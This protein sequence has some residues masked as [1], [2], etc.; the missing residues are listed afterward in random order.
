MTDYRR[1]VKLSESGGSH[2]TGA[3]TTGTYTSG[4]LTFNLDYNDNDTLDI[5]IVTNNNVTSSD[6]VSVTP[7]N[8]KIDNS[9]S[10]QSIQGGDVFTISRSG[11]GSYKAELEITKKTGG[12]AENPTY[13]V[14]TAEV[15]GTFI[16]DIPNAF[17]FTNLANVSTGSVH[18]DYVIMQGFTGS[19]TISRTSGSILFAVSSGTSQ[20]ASSAFTA[21]NKTVT[22]GQYLH[23]KMTA[24]SSFSTTVSGT[25]SC[26]GVTSTWNIE[27]VSQDTTAN[28]F[29]FG[30]NVTGATRDQYYYA[31]AQITGFTGTLTASRTSGTSRGSVPDM[32]FDV[33]SGTSIS[34]LQFQSSPHSITNGQYLHVR[35]RASASYSTE[36]NG[37]MTV[38]GQSVSWSVTTEAQDTTPDAFD[39][40]DVTGANLD[41]DVIS[42][43][44]ITGITGLVN[45]S[46][47]GTHA[48]C[49]ASLSSTP[50]AAD[51]GQYASSGTIE[52]NMYLHVLIPTANAFNNTR[53]TTI[54]VGDRTDSYS[55]TTR[56]P[57][58][59]I[60]QFSLGANITGATRGS[61]HY[62]SVQINNF[63]S[64]LAVSLTINSFSGTNAGMG[65]LIS[66]S[67]TAP[68]SGYTTTS[69]TMTQGQYIHVQLTAATSF[70]GHIDGTLTAGT[71][72][73]AK[74][75]TIRITTEAADTTPNAF[76]FTNVTGQEP[77]TQIT[78]A[79]EITGINTTTSV[80]VSGGGA[81]F[82]TSSSPS[83]SPSTFDTNN[84]FVGSGSID[85]VHVRMNAPTTFSATNTCTI[86]IGTVSDTFSVT[87]RAADVTPDAFSLGSDITDANLEAEYVRNARILGIEAGV[88]ASISGGSA[89]FAVSNSTSVPT[90]SNFTASNKTVTNGQ[91]VH[92]KLAAS[93]SGNTTTSTTLTVGG[94]TDSLSITTGSTSGTG[95]GG[96]SVGGGGASIGNVDYGLT[97]FGPDGTTEVFGSNVRQTNL[98]VLSSISLSNGSS[99][100]FNCAF[101]NDSSKVFIQ[102]IENS[103]SR[104]GTL[105][106]TTTST[107]FTVSNNTG[108]TV[109]ASVVAYRIA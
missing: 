108:V 43:R 13:T 101:A 19:L 90:S 58:Q 34:G 42:T 22:S 82:G 27:T 10:A 53:S 67:S 41:A 12:T 47:S 93:A 37:T 57:N 35:L 50:P 109:G 79:K 62:R 72:S 8:C 61:V 54:T 2:T 49:A 1:N 68:T 81:T 11:V 15:N 29:S 32:Q 16:D 77:G 80:S 24:S 92:V 95:S 83:I 70:S 74:S 7:T 78:Q 4:A 33:G 99:Q 89:T 105:T 20:P 85:S 91:Y 3:S 52:N 23:V 26:G 106:L 5:G 75:D 18:Y 60:S 38:G 48:S 56:S 31:Y 94:V 45:R 17:P 25:L 55:V 97:V 103:S 9:T 30:D 69:K 76:D 14:S 59:S 71:G 46:V 98:Q 65:F 6:Y 28:S 100:T 21:S 73:D 64:N 96:S 40:S 102:V 88:T 44:Q 107:N 84:K 66:N 63:E 104:Y 39:F 51:S 36:T 86:T 87:T